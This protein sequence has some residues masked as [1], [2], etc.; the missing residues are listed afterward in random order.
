MKRL[1]LLTVLFPAAVLCA[2]AQFD[3]LISS[4][5][6]H[7][8]E[9]R[10]DEAVSDLEDALS[11]ASSGAD[12]AEAY[13]RLSRV[14]LAI[15]DRLIDNGRDESTILETFEQ[16]E[17]YGRNAIEADSSN[18]LG[19]YWTS[20]NVGKWGQTRGIVNSLIKAGPMRDLLAEA[21]EREPDHA[22][23]YYVLGQLYAQVPGFIS[24]GNADYAVSFGRKSVDLEAE[25]T[26]NDPE[27]EFNQDMKI[28]LGSHLIQ[29]DWS[30]RKREREQSGKAENYRSTSDRLEKNFHY[31]GVV[32][33]PRMDDK[34]EARRLLREAISALE[35]KRD[36]SDSEDRN[37][38][39]ARTLLNEL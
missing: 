31:E 13:W 4:A 23:S 25:Q 5:D 39:E 27:E 8:E 38:E 26:R 3:E 15:G 19:Y 36:R 32:D 9:D 12:R 16:G 28:Q 17:E 30:R 20:A 7:Y 18:H 14:T 6:A 22:D 34:E 1:M 29:R 35:R 33:L 2:H 10:L 21:I 24:F 11:E 37:L